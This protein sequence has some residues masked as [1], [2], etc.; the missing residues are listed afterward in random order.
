MCFRIYDRNSVLISYAYR[1]AKICACGPI[2][3]PDFSYL[4]CKI[5]S[6]D[7]LNTFQKY[8]EKSC[9]FFYLKQ[10]NLSETEIDLSSAMQNQPD[11]KSGFQRQKR[12][13]FLKQRITKLGAQ[14]IQN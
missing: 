10:F 14:L 7:V 1:D 8:K 9:E 3:Y 12:S 6:S 11:T 2:F 4:E 13:E 5:I